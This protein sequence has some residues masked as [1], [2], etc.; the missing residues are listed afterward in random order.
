MPRPDDRPSLRGI[1]ARFTAGGAGLLRTRLELATIELAQQRD[2]LLLRLGLI[3][4]GVLALLFGALGVGAYV[5]LYFWE[6]DRLIAT[7]A[8]A[9][10][11]IVL[12][13]ILLFLAIRL[14]RDTSPFEATIAE[15]GKDVELLRE[16]LGRDDPKRGSP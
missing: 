2:R 4:G 11:F 13:A 7:L 14:G 12:G 1:L 8:V 6:T 9:A 3:V 10:V 16:V 5:V 15:F